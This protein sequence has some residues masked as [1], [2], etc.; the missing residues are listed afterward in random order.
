M[1]PKPVECAEARRLRREGLAM[2]V[3][4]SRLDVSRASVHLWTSDLE[5]TPEQRARVAAAA[6]ELRT[7]TWRERNRARRRAY[8]QE[9]RERARQ[10]ELL[11]QAGCML[12]WAE[13]AK[14]RNCVALA[15][16]D[17]HMV[18]FFVRFLRE[19]F[20]VD[21]ARFAVCLNVHVKRSLDHR[22]RG[23]LARRARPPEIVPSQAHAQPL[24]NVDQRQEAEQAALRRLQGVRRRHP[25][26][27]A[28]LRRHPGV[29]RLRGA[30]VARR[31]AD[32]AAARQ[33]PLSGRGRPSEVSSP[34]RLPRRG[35]RRRCAS[36]SGRPT[37]P[38]T[39]R[40]CRR[41]RSGR[42]RCRRP[43]RRAR[44]SARAP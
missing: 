14:E 5:L 23:L 18:R 8:Q 33:E 11:H 15:N 24:P 28:H 2:K 25:H 9:G 30:S 32:Q 22:D 42:C 4:A 7:A 44:R 16:S 13:G 6:Q 12:Y 26:R 31:A 19:C 41:H 36:A 1:R 34:E 35:S 21:P 27:A 43:G 38:T 10:G 3:I 37:R 17:V 39:R 29:R 40:S 20:D